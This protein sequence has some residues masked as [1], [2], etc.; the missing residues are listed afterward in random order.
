MEGAD[1]AG[2]WNVVANQRSIA[3]GQKMGRGFGGLDAATLSAL[4]AARITGYTQRQRELGWHD[5]RS[6]GLRRGR[7]WHDADMPCKLD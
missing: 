7:G 4:R 2:L 5:D 3:A 1:I 6:V